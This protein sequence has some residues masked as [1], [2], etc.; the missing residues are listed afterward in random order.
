MPAFCFATRDRQTRRL[1]K[2]EPDR[3]VRGRGTHMEEMTNTTVEQEQTSDSFMEGWN[4]EEP[5]V[6]EPENQPEAQAAEVGGEEIPAKEQPA[7]EPEGQ[8]TGTEET[9]GEPVTEQPERADV[10]KTWTLNHLGESRQV[11]E[12]DMVVLAQKGM[13]YDRIRGK[14]DEAKPVLELFGGFAKQAGMSVADYVSFI[15]TQAKQQGGMS[16][17]EAKRAVELEDREAAVAAKEAAEAARQAAQERTSAA[18]NDAESRRRADILEFQ[19]TFPDVAKAPQSIPPEVWAEVNRG[20]SLVAA[21]SKYAIAQA[22]TA[23]KT[24]ERKA[25]AVTQNQKNAGRSTGSMKTAGDG[26][27]GRDPFV[28]GFMSGE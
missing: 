27:K 28:E 20:A 19:K 10:P 13:D 3:P 1:L 8:Q 9:G 16:E 17:A 2:Y 4:D 24:A 15:R 23:Q 11:G 7:A 21:Y 22:Q 25:E 26:T 18:A 6:S 14:W 12:A 5:A